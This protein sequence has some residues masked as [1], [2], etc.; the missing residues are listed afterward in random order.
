MQGYTILAEALAKQNIQHCY[1]IVGIPPPIKA[2]L[3]SNLD[4]PFKA[5]A[6][7]TT[8]SEI[9]NKPVIVQDIPVI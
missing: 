2:S 3:L 1:G 8:D 6:S 4:S 7:T 9:N 5:M